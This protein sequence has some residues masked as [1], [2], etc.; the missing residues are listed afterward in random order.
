MSEDRR[1]YLTDIPS[2]KLAVESGL[3]VRAGSDAYR[4]IKD[5]I[6]QWL[7]H[8]TGHPENWIGLHGREGTQ[9]ENQL[10]MTPVYI[11]PAPKKFDVYIRFAEEITAYD[12][13]E[14]FD[15]MMAAFEHRA[16]FEITGHD[17]IEQENK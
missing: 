6:G 14:A 3:D 2:I 9:Y 17:I 7:I 15:K 16:G 1:E 11:K 13:E 12:E 8:Y 10:N 4:V 5:S